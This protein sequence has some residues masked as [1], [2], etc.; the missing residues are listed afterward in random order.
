MS[1]WTTLCCPPLFLLQ[2]WM[3]WVFQSVQN[4]VSPYSVKA[5]GWGSSP[6]TTTSLQVVGVVQGSEK[7]KGGVLRKSRRRKM[8]R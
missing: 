7:V 6:F 5:K 4:K 8:R 2:E 3:E 1:E